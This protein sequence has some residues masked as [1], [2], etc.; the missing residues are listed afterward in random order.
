MNE[1]FKNL[2]SHLVE[3]NRA[4]LISNT[5]FFILKTD[6]IKKLGVVCAP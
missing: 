5:F 1:L 2:N 3:A 4:G 6:P